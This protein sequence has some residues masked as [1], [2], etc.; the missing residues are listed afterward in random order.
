VNVIAK[1]LL[2]SFNRETKH[3]LFTG[4]APDVILNNAV[5]ITEPVRLKFDCLFLVL[6]SK[7]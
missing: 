2:G 4:G 1:F 3:R 7:R 6:E 5:A